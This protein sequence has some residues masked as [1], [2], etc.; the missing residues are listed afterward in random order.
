MI[1]NVFAS[2]SGEKTSFIGDIGDILLSIVVD[3]GEP[4]VS[5]M[6]DIMHST[7][8]Y[9]EL[10]KKHTRSPSDS[11]TLRAVDWKEGWWELGLK[12]KQ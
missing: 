11:R 7:T 4:T 3:I 10:L 5:Y 9:F 6:L 2:G 1:R 12:R 8:F